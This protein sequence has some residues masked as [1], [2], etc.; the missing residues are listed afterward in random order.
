MYR[1]LQLFTL[2]AVTLLAIAAHP[3]PTPAKPIQTT[4]D[5]SIASLSADPRVQL[6][7]EELGLD[8]EIDD[9]G[10][11]RILMRSPDGTRTQIAWISS[12]TTMVGS[13]EIR[14]ITSAAYLTEG[15]LPAP[16]ANRLLESSSTLGLGAWQTFRDERRSLAV[17]AARIDANSNAAALESALYAVLD[18]ADTMEAELTGED[19]F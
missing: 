17:F 12:Q 3:T 9:S 8:Y 5:N 1:R 19:Y 11:Y 16:V 10:D 6:A 14:E 4:P 13:L 7:L 15:P 18:T 2:S